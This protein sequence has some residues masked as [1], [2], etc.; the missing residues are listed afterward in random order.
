LWVK[1]LELFQ[2]TTVRFRNR[3]NIGDF[4]GRLV[5]MVVEVEKEPVK[6]AFSQRA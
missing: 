4:A 2:I 3:A 5:G 1:L 6:W